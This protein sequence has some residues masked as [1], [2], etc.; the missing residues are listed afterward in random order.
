VKSIWISII[1][2]LPKIILAIAV[3]ICVIR[4]QPGDLPKMVQSLTSSN[5]FCLTG[6]I[7]AGVVIVVAIG[8][9]AIYIKL[10]PKNTDK[11]L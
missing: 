5:V 7:L 2:K 11:K 6:W 1:E 3:L 10:K 4:A 8:G 9:V